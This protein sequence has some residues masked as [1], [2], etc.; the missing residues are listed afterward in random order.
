MD[1][2]FEPNGIFEDVVP[3]YKNAQ[4]K[5]TG[6]LS[7]R[8]LD[9]LDYLIYQL[10]QR[11]IYININTLVARHFTEADG[12]PD[13]DKLGMAAKPVSLFDARL[14]ELQKQY[15]KDLLT[16]LNPYTKL[17]YCDDPSVCLVEITNEN[18]LAE[19]NPSS[20][21][22]YYRKEFEKLFMGRAPVDSEVPVPLPSWGIE[23]HSNA[24]ISK[25]ESDNETTLIVSNVTDTNWHLQYRVTGVKLKKD[26][27]YLLKFTAKATGGHAPQERV[28]IAVISQQAYLPWSNLGLY[29]TIELS[30]DFQAFEFPFTASE[31]C[32]N[33]KI[34]F[35]VGYNPGTI[36]IKDVALF[37]S[38]KA[39]DIRDFKAYLEGKYLKEMRAYLRDTVSIKV[40]IGIGGHWNPTQQKL[41]KE[42]LDY[43][44]K[45]GYWDHPQFPHKSWDNSD[46]RMHKKSMLADKSLGLIG[47]FK[48]S[49]P[50]GM[51]YVISEW[52]HCY[53]N[54]YAYETPVLL[55]STARQEDWDALF[56]FAFSHGW[57]GNTNYDNIDNYFNINPDAQQLILCSYGSRIFLK[58]EKPVIP[59]VGQIKNTGS[60]WNASGRFDW[61][62]APT[63][64]KQP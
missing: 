38:S 58:A 54:P 16:H 46:F 33:S 13:A 63:L 35:I 20:L 22:E 41:Q 50:K 17:R 23:Q 3:A 1:F 15:A 21:P 11:G 2:Y 24:G 14:I 12:V 40:P 4:M 37:E 6:H 60:G 61:G 59:K 8:Q 48:K 19:L 55:A 27:G 5:P 43:V 7:P 30:K 26:A 42:C 45:H 32:D 62:T 49:A 9:K 28:P 39:A 57:G 53:P 34:G 29:G 52:M 44:D 36:T 56:Q 47:E 64:F 51:P 18:T 10:K 25:S 31:S